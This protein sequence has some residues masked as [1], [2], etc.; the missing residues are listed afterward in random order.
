MMTSK[1][2]NTLIAALAAA[3]VGSAAVPRPAAAGGSVSLSYNPTRGRDVQALQMGLELYSLYNGPKH[4]ANVRQRGWNNMAG[5][6][7]YGAGN[8]GIISQE[9]RGHS[10]TLR[11]YGNG[12]SY[13]IF[14]FGRNTSVNVSQYRQG[15]AGTTLQFGW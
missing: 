13:G 12:N 1:I 10:A 15:S 9:G 8:Q 14:Q 5:I 11:Q 3:L 7:Q 4:G 6:A 2:S